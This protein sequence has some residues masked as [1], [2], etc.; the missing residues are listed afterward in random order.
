MKMQALQLKEIKLPESGA[1]CK[2]ALTYGDICDIEDALYGSIEM[3]IGTDAKQKLNAGALTK[4]KEMILTRGLRSWEFESE[5]G[6]PLPITY[7]N[8]RQL[9]RKDGDF[10]HA[11]IRRIYEFKVKDEDKK[12]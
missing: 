10:L 4:E 5:D 1:T 2:I 6:S 11:S 8:I 9:T 7:D 3:E 12:K